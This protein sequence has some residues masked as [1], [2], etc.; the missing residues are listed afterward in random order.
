MNILCAGESPPSLSMSPYRSQDNSLIVN[1]TFF[2]KIHIIS[3]QIKI[4][5]LYALNSLIV[6]ISEKKHIFFLLVL[7]RRSQA[8][9]TSGDTLI[10]T[11]SWWLI[12]N[13]RWCWPACTKRLWRSTN[14]NLDFYCYIINCASHNPSRHL[15]LKKTKQLS[16]VSTSANVR[17]QSEPGMRHELIIQCESLIAS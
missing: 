11:S 3:L 15:S 17:W 4:S 7:S 6:F 12:H 8:A 2:F 16:V 13:E 5:G 9:R 1:W 14:G 10:I